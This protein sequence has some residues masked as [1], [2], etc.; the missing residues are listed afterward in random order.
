MSLDQILQ[1]APTEDGIYGEHLRRHLLNLEKDEK[2]LAAMKQIITVDQPVSISTKEAFKLVDMGLVQ[3]QDN[4]VLLTG[5]LY[6]R[7]FKEQLINSGQSN[8]DSEL[9]VATTIGETPIRTSLW[10]EE[11]TQIYSLCTSAPWSLPLDAL[12][13]PV[14]L[15]GGLGSFAEAAQELL[16]IRSNW[17]AQIIDDTMAANK[18][19]RIKPDRPLLVQIP[20]EINNQISSLVEFTSERFVICTIW[21]S[22]AAL[23]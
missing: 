6:R 16:R 17:L 18:L 8:I 12:V 1:I 11:N 20:F 13:I 15:R 22:R 10:Q 23:R 5:D 7:Y 2:L 19:G 21:C 14:G 9:K 4:K 3:R